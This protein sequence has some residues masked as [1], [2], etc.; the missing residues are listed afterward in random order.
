MLITLN[1]CVNR[2]LVLFSKCVESPA[3][4]KLRF[5]YFFWAPP[6]L[7]FNIAL[8]FFQFNRY[9]AQYNDMPSPLSN[10]EKLAESSRREDDMRRDKDRDEVFKS[11]H[12]RDPRLAMPAQRKG[13]NHIA[14]FSLFLHQF[15]FYST[16]LWTFF[17]KYSVNPFQTY[18]TKI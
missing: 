15:T 9:V 17:Q 13:T 6:G 4:R 8:V 5:C 10:S 7:N 3:T 2:K 16:F 18:L 12:D 11:Y 1:I 14:L